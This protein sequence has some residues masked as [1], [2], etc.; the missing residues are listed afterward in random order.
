MKAIALLPIILLA[1]CAAT[2]EQSP[3]APHEAVATA[4]SNCASAIKDIAISAGG[5]AASKVA[6]VGAIE[7]LCGS[8]QMVAFQ[9]R[10]EPSLGTSLW[11]AAL[12]VGDIAMRFYGI[13]ANRDVGINASNNAANT[14]IAGYGAFSNIAGAGFASTAS[15]ASRIQA[16]AAN[17]TNTTT[18]NTATTTTTSTS[19]GGSGVIG[20]GSYT[21]TTL[22]GSQNPITSTTS[23]RVCSTSATG[24]LTCQGG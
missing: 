5:D 13:K 17:I 9:P 19:L 3:I 12:S 18:N 11:Q 14:T 21:T 23:P 22:T 2:K 1:G 4:Q 7:R 15:I 20:N 24:V 10:Q 16:P 8:G 6:A